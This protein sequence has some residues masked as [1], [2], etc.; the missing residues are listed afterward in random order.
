[1]NK[2]LR[3]ISDLCNTKEH[4]Q[5]FTRKK[6]KIS[7]QS[8]IITDPPKTFENPNIIDINSVTIEHPKI[9]HK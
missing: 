4:Y 1:M 8:K 3:K 5:S 2:Q 7:K 9:S 6:N